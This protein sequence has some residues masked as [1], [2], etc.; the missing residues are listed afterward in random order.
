MDTYFK[1]G[2]TFFE[3]RSDEDI[4]RGIAMLMSFSVIM[5]VPYGFFESAINVAL[6]SIIPAVYFWYE[7]KLYEEYKDILDLPDFPGDTSSS[8]Y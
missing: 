6:A 1:S 4:R 8:G 3:L 5:S 7:R 2:A